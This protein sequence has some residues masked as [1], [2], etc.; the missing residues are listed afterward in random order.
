MKRENN[1]FLFILIPILFIILG[2]SYFTMLPAS[3]Q[4]ENGNGTDS[5]EKGF[6]YVGNAKSNSISVIDLVTNKVIK[7]IKLEVEPM[8]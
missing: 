8:I 2:T 7:N 4:I 5:G 6:L 3:A 1:S